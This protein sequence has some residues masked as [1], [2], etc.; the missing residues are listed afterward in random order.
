VRKKRVKLTRAQTAKLTDI[1]ARPPLW[2]LSAEDWQRT[3][4]APPATGQRGRPPKPQPPSSPAEDMV[5]RRVP[6]HKRFVAKPE[7]ARKLG[8]EKAAPARR[9]IGDKTRAAV[10]AA[11]R[12]LN[13]LAI[14]LTERIDRIADIVHKHDSTVRK[15]L[16]TSK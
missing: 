1:I 5:A 13:D 3:D 15:A 12:D 7:R 4:H 9:A 2:P 11:A 16:K 8:R 14:P 10:V 6:L